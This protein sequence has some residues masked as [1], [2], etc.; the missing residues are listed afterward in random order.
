MRLKMYDIYVPLFE[1]T[2]KEIVYGEAKDMVMRGL[3]PLGN[4]TAPY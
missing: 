2:K 4:S 3:L 1:E